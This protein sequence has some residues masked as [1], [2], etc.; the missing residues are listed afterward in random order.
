M[1][2]SPFYGVFMQRMVLGPIPF[3]GVFMQ[4]M[5]L[6]QAKRIALSD[7]PFL[8]LSTGSDNAPV[9]WNGSSMLRLLHA[10]RVVEVGAR[11]IRFIGSQWRPSALFYA[12]NT[13]AGFKD[14][15]GH[16]KAGIHDTCHAVSHALCSTANGFLF[17]YDTMAEVSGDL[18]PAFSNHLSLQ[19]WSNAPQTCDQSGRILVKSPMY[20]ATACDVMRGHLVTMYKTELHQAILFS[21]TF[22]PMAYTCILIS[23]L[24]CIYGATAETISSSF[25]RLSLVVVVVAIVVSNCLVY[26]ISGIAFMTVED[27]VYFWASV[28][29]SCFSI[30]CYYTTEKN[31]SYFIAD[32]CIYALGTI[33]SALYRG[34]ETPYASLFVI[35]FSIRQWQKAL[36][37]CC[38]FQ[39]SELLMQ[40]DLLFS[41]A[42]MCLTAE[43]GL[44]PQFLDSEDWPIYAGIGCLIT[45]WVAWSTPRTST[46]V[47]NE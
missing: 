29:G 27:E 33:S 22:G 41:S 10:S 25:L 44:V 2:L 31:P 21:Q 6:G 11:G 35:V 26:S 47:T 30:F 40:M 12:S 37:L 8:F 14:R 36:A 18:S 17:P 15:W 24:F 45:F 13:T 23:A 34:A 1:N 38:C 16:N 28:V 20:T 32:A 9:L 4:L 7:G 43:I 5:V 42:Y 39:E 46:T 19:F 3:Y